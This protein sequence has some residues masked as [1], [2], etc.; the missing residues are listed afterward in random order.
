MPASAR[1]AL[2]DGRRRRDVRRRAPRTRRRCRTGSTPIDCRAWRPARRTPRRPSPHADEMLN[3]P[4]RSPP[5]PQVSKT[6][7]A[8]STAHGLR[9]HRP[10]EPD[11]F[12]RPLA[13]HGQAD[14]QRG[15][16]RGRARPAMISAIAAAASSVVRSSR[17][18]E[19]LEAARRTASQRP[20][21][22]AASAGP[23]PV[24]IDS[25][26]N[27]T[28]CIG[29][30]RCR[31]A[32]DRAVFAGPRGDLELR[33][34]P[35]RRDD[36]RVIARRENGS[37]A[38]EHAAAVVLDRSTSCRASARGAR[39]TRAAEHHADRLVPE[40]HAEHRHRRPKRRMTSDVMPASSGRPGPGRDHDL[41]RAP[42][43][44]SRRASPRRCGAP[45]RPHP[46]R[47]G[48]APGCR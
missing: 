45:H 35:P 4:T 6:S 41:R 39:T 19:L 37:Q 44:R 34:Q 9:P 21:S 31:S 3:V 10:R 40:A 38:G 15:D 5:V 2:D 12:G 7:A 43:P 22:C 14:Q 29:H 42:A 11:D 1:H 28:P 25:G 48:T 24:R 27:C 32:H 30:S 20:G 23:S 47:R 13:F 18:S 26:W 46:A 36:Q 17:R 16:L 8:A 33:R